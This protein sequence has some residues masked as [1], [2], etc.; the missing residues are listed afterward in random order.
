MS[1]QHPATH[2]QLDPDTDDVGELLQAVVEQHAVEYGIHHN[3]SG[4][5]TIAK[6]IQLSRQPHIIAQYPAL[7]RTIQARIQTGRDQSNPTRL[8]KLR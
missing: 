7:C 5:L 4:P 6:A 1:V 2:I 8:D 3:M